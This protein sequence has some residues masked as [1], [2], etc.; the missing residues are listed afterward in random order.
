MNLCAS[1]NEDREHGVGAGVNATILSE[2]LEVVGLGEVSRSPFW[3]RKKTMN[4]CG[5]DSEEREHGVGV[6]V[7]VTILSETLEVVGLVV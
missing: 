3:L 4:L 5:F 2:T 7:N 1:D 6:G